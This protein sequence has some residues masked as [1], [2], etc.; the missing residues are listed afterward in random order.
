M[1]KIYWRPKIIREGMKVPFGY[2]RVCERWDCFGS[3]IML[4]PFCWLK[5]WWL[6]FYY[7]LLHNTFKRYDW[8]KKIINNRLKLMLD[9]QKIEE[10][11]S[12]LRLE[13]ILREEIRKCYDELQKERETKT[14]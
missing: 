5:R 14:N 11:K 13:R 1:I 2:G 7:G 6:N 8:E 3:E 9:F 12:R 10:E 4:M